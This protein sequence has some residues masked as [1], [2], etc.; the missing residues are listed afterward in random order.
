MADLARVSKFLRQL[1]N[2]PSLC[3]KLWQAP[4]FCTVLL[5]KCP[6]RCSSPCAHWSLG[7]RAALPRAAANTAASKQPLISPEVLLQDRDINA[8]P[9]IDRHIIPFKPVSAMSLIKNEKCT[10]L[11]NVRP[12]IYPQRQKHAQGVTGTDLSMLP[13]GPNTCSPQLLAAEDAF[14]TQRAHLG[15]LVV[16]G[17]LVAVPDAGKLTALRDVFVAGFGAW[18]ALSSCFIQ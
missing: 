3:N 10:I 13:K 17:P 14:P 4:T 9:H 11:R 1:E 16:K 5:Q 2:S 8:V 18:D 12:L 15:Q 6:S 7:D